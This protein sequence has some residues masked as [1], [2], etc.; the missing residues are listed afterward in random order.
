[1][2]HLEHPHAFQNPISE[3]EVESSTASTVLGALVIVRKI[4]STSKLDLY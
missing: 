2:S 4:N 3:I 1:M